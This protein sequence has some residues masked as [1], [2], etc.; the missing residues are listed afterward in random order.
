[1]ASI[2]GFSGV[3]AL[4]AADQLAIYSAQAGGD[5]KASMS[6]LLAYLQANLTIPEA[7]D[8]QFESL[9]TFTV[10]PTTQGNSVRV[11]WTPS[12]TLTNGIVTLPPVGQARNQQR[13]IVSCTQIVAGLAVQ[14]NGASVSSAPSSMSAGGFWTLELNSFNLTWYR[15]G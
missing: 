14:G 6:L 9:A 15:V 1:M 7:T 10:T 4:T 13:V 12:A 2:Y 5:R 11:I 8:Q 3:D